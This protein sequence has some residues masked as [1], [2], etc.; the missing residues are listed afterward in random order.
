MTLRSAENNLVYLTLGANHLKF[1][2]SKP[3]TELMSLLKKYYFG[4]LGEDGYLQ[5]PGV[6]SNSDLFFSC[7]CHVVVEQL[8]KTMWTLFL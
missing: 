5:P 3:I 7:M 6:V 2:S 8:V 1:L 4:A